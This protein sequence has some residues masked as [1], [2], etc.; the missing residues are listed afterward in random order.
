MVCQMTEFRSQR[1][2]VRIEKSECGSRKSENIRQKTGDK[3][4]GKGVRIK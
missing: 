3:E 1:S 4:Q 2:D